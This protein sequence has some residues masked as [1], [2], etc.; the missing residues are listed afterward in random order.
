MKSEF[1]KA[2]AAGLFCFTV[3]CGAR[4]SEAGTFEEIYM[5]N[6]QGSYER[7]EIFEWHEQPWLYLKTPEKR[8]G[9]STLINSSSWYDPNDNLIFKDIAN[10]NRKNERWFSLADWDSVKTL[11]TWEVEARYFNPGS[12]DG[13]GSTNFTVTPE[14]VSSVLFLLGGLS[15]FG[16]EYKK[17]RKFRT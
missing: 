2:V 17:R 8:R 1:Y 15:L 6:A 13:G 16:F 10:P 11:G 14:P 7:V 4:E 3:F 5:T 12:I 9:N